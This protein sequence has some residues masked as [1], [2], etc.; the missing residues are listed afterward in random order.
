MDLSALRGWAGIFYSWA[1]RYGYAGIFAASALEGTGLPIPI[2]IPFMAAGLLM[3]K[4]KMTFAV[5]WIIATVGEVLGNLGGYW[6]GYRGGRAFV[7]RFG[8]RIGVTDKQLAKVSRYFERY[9]PMT[10]VAARWFGII[11]TPAIVAAGLGKMRLEAYTF[12]SLI[13]EASWTAGWLWLFYAFSGH[14]QTVI[15]LVKPHLA[16]VIAVAVVVIGGAWWWTVRI[17]RR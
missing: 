2:E 3:V 16:W 15:G 11:R 6:V 12:Y 10:I 7:D 9:G 17:V 8:L 5:V 1:V 14:Y 13:A 4:G